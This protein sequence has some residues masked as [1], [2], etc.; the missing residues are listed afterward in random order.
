MNYPPSCSP[1][2]KEGR[3][4]GVFLST[5]KEEGMLWSVPFLKRV[6]LVSIY[7]ASD[8]VSDITRPNSRR[9]TSP[10]I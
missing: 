1:L 4:C 10:A 7:H 5:V 6:Y 2:T 9:N 8:H 3:V